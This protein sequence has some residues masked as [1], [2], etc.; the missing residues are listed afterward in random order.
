MSKVSNIVKKLKRRKF[1]IAVAESCTGGMD[2]L[3]CLLLVWLLIQINPK[4]KFSGF[5]KMS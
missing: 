3:K 5:Q 2:L 4:L 1:K